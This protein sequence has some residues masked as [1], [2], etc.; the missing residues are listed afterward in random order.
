MS[1]PRK[2]SPARARPARRATDVA[3]L[4]FSMQMVV[5]VV[6]TVLAVAGATWASTASVK[7]E[8]ASVKSDLRDILTQMA[9]Q[10][11][12]EEVEKKLQDERAANMREA[13]ESMRRE[14]KLQQ[15]EFQSFKETMLSQ[16]A[17]NSTQRNSR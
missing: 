5:L 9:K 2:K 7:S 3:H 17:Q 16:N 14:L 12:V 1:P 11:E 4:Q 8:L 13:V 6:S 10:K 15:I